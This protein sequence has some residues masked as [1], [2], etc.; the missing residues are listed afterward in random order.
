MPGI[1][2]R[3]AL[4]GELDETR[5]GLLWAP[6]SRDLAPKFCRRQPYHDQTAGDSIPYYCIG[7]GNHLAVLLNPPEVSL[8]CWD[9]NLHRILAQ[10][11]IRTLLRCTIPGARLPVFYGLVLRTAF[12]SV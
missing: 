12:H 3:R 6:L 10:A 7:Y 4:P 1:Y 11:T 2:P 5:I 9:Q 8:T